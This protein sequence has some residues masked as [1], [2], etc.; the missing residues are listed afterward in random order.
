MNARGKCF[1]GKQPTAIWLCLLF[2]CLLGLPSATAQRTP[3]GSEADLSEQPSAEWW[4]H[5][6]TVI[7]LGGLSLIG[8]QWRAAARIR[9]GLDTRPIVAQLNGTLRMGPLGHYAPDVDEPY[10]LL[11]LVD[12]VRLKRTQSRPLYARIGT[13]DGMR[14]GIGHVVSFYSS[15]VAWD[16]RTVG[17]E[18][19]YG[20]GAISLSGFTGDLR[21]GG[22]SGL[23]LEAVPFFSARHLP[24]RSTRLGVSYVVDRNKESRLAAYSADAQLVLFSSGGVQFMPYFSYAWYPEYGNGIGFGADVF[25]PDFIDLFSLRLRI[26]GF[27]NGHQFTPGYFGSLYPVNNL[28]AR[29]TKGGSDEYVGLPLNKVRSA[30]DLLTELW[31]EVPPNFSM[32]YF[33]RRSFGYQRLSEFHFRLFVRRAERA[34]FELGVDKAGGAGAFGLFSRFD[35]LSALVFAA[36]YQLLGPV[37]LSVTAR[38][39]FERID[40]EGAPRYLVQR[41]FE[42]F[43]GVRLQF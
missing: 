39:T 42:P 16:E 6:Q 37:R 32:H 29:I 24:A 19:S 28:H 5:D 9:V 41:R 10:D 30:N 38:Y 25:A 14:L 8:A 33:Y 18:V 15:S 17:A 43:A 40:S 2:T 27:Y 36:H 4:R 1:P 35:D 12:Y 7:A 21:L 31:I 22:V 26:G 34:R 11:R 20:T 23:R 3:F 13:L